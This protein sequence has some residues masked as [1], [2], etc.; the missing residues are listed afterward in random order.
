LEFATLDYNAPARNQ[1]RYQLIGADDNWVEIGTQRS[2]TFIHLPP[3]TYTFRVQGS[4]S[5]GIWNEKITE[6]EIIVLPPW[7]HTWWAY[8]TYI[9]LVLSGIWRYIQFFIKRSKLRQELA[10]ERREADRAKD[11]DIQKSQ[12]YMNMTHE[13]RTPLT[14]ILGMSKQIEDNPKANMKKGLDMINRNGQQLLNLINQMLN[15]SKLE[16]GKMKLELET[17]DIIPFLKTI[18]DY[19]KSF[20]YHKEIKLH[21]LP[22]EEKIITNFDP[23]KL[24]QII[25]NLISNAYKFTPNNGHIYISIRKENDSISIKVK[26]TG[27]GIPK[28]DLEKVFERFYQVDNSTTRHHEGTGIGLSLTK[29]LIKLMDGKISVQSPPTGVSI[30]TEFK[31]TLPISLDYISIDS[32]RGTQDLLKEKLYPIK[33]VIPNTNLAT[34]DK[35]PTR[36]LIPKKKEDAIES[37]K[38]LILVVE[39]NVDV[40]NYIASC[41]GDYRLSICYNGQEGLALAISEIPDLI[42][43]DV[44]MP[45]MD[46]FELCKKVKLDARTD[47]IPIIILTA[48]ADFDSK[49]EG[50]EIGANAYLPKPFE[51]KELLLNINNLFDLRN[52]LRRYYHVAQNPS[53]AIDIENSNVVPDQQEDAFVKK[54]RKIIE[55]NI[56]DVNLSVELLTKTIH[57]SHSQFGRKLHALTGMSP[58]RFIRY[59]RLKKAKELLEDQDLGI[60][61]IAYECGFN[62][63]SYFSRTFKND[64]GVS[65]NIWRKMKKG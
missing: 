37:S 63:P 13:F 26:D 21:F 32:K 22:E 23:E 17:R 11:L 24:E 29:E 6:L 2:A 59:V 34:S 61:T 47:H 9:L 38:P 30:G 58:I 60:K 51:K 53:E 50:L 44:M 5:Q 20:S 36:D 45:I 49:L 14:I 16:S 10:F 64:F 25:S 31:V 27:R 65:P 3:K 33:E 7:W 43:S 41:L 35:K 39:D 18:I 46:G 54:V 48:R 8:L 4:N 57:L 19:F 56:V 15:L 62:D 1:Y 55:A 52:N 40:S 12:L 42:I 28:S